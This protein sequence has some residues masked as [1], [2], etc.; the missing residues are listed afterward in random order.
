[1][2]R[3]Y[4]LVWSFVLCRLIAKIP[5]LAF[6]GELGGGA[7]LGWLSWLIPLAIAEIC[8]QWKAGAREPVR[9]PRTPPSLPR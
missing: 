3:S 8:L 1:M 7:A 4:V 9:L 5:P 2:I 6:L